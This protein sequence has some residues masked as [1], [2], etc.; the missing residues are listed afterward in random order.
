MIFS[1]PAYL[2][3]RMLVVLTFDESGFADA[4]ACAAVDQADCKSPTGPN[5]SNPGFSPIL[6]LF[7]L[8]SPP[9][10]NFVYPGGG[11]IGAVLFNPR[12]IRAGTVNSTVSYNHYSALR[13]YEDLLG[14]TEG[15]DD[16]LGHLGYAS[17]PGLMPFGK[18]VF[19]P[20]LE[21]ADAR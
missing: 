10:K 1:S 16:G 19:E 8:Q 12:Y 18:D 6:G 9:T 11:Q 3:G 4:R 14:L 7:H 17:Q 13:S 15:G 21:H 20:P 5:V 2:S